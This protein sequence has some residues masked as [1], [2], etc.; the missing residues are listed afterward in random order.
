MHPVSV[1]RVE[2]DYGSSSFIPDPGSQD[3]FTPSLDRK[4]ALTG[5]APNQP[6]A[7]NMKRPSSSSGHSSPVIPSTQLGGNGVKIEANSDNQDSDKTVDSPHEP[8]SVHPFEPAVLP[9]SVHLSHTQ[10]EQSYTAITDN[11]AEPKDDSILSAMG[12]SGDSSEHS[13]VKIEP[14]TEN[15]LELEIT[16]VEMAG[17]PTGFQGD[18]GQDISGGMGYDQ[19]DSRDSSFD[20]SG[21]QYSK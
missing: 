3:T 17:G 21:N 8:I 10:T 12:Q 19:S 1:T 9:S 7:Q 16:G 14:V 13:N 18:W 5:R 15:E 4:K 20:Q 2:E 11:G 6:S